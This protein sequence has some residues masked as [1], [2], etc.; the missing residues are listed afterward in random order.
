[1]RILH[2][3]A[4]SGTAYLL[5]LQT[6]LSFWHISI[7]TYAYLCALPSLLQP[8]PGEHVR[9]VRPAGAVRGL[10]GPV[11]PHRHPLHL[12]GPPGTSII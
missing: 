9:G 12:P 5:K 1:M 6:T 8:V 3:I 7:A 4:V 11:L 2:N 10:Q